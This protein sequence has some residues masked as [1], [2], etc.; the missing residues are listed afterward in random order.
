MNYYLSFSI[1][2]VVFFFPRDGGRQ[3][4]SNFTLV[5]LSIVLLTPELTLRLK[6][7]YKTT[8]IDPTGASEELRGSGVRARVR[9]KHFTYSRGGLSK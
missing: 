4:L 9:R 2:F 3:F 6:S 8:P 7:K 5:I 1:S